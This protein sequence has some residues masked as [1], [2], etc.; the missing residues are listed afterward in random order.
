[1]DNM[2]V[3][4]IFG[5]LAVIACF[6]TAVSVY[7]MARFSRDLPPA[8]FI[9]VMCIGAIVLVVIGFIKSYHVCDNCG[10][11]C[12]S[13]NYCSECGEMVVAPDIICQCGAKYD[14]D[15]NYCS[16]CG[17]KLENHADATSD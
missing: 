17:M 16:N 4:L 12:F 15:T 2:I 11:I 1:M 10:T 13:E 6:I 3:Y 14:A 8:I 5:I 9:W 7:D